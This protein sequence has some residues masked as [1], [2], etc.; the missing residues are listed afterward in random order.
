[1][2]FSSFAPN[3][4]LDDFLLSCKLLLPWNWFKLRYGKAQ[5]QL[6]T[7]IETYF[8]RNCILFD[9]G[10]NALYQ[11]LKAYHFEA[12]SEIIIQALT[13]SVV[14]HA[15][16]RARLQPV[17]TDIDSS[18][19]LDPAKLTASITPQTKAVI[20][21]H[22]FGIPAQIKEIKAI[23]EQHNLILIEDL[24]LSLGAQYE[25]KPVG[26]FGDSAILSF[27]SFKVISCSRGGATITKNE[28]VWQ[29]LQLNRHQTGEAPPLKML[30]RNLW[31][32]I[33]FYISK[34]IYD[35]CKI[36]KIILFTFKKLGLLPIVTSTQEKQASGN[37]PTYTL[38][39]G[40]AIQALHQWHKMGKFRKHRRQIANIY[41]R[42][43]GQKLPKG[44]SILNYP[45]LTPKQKQVFKKAAKH[46]IMLNNWY[47]QPI[48]PA[49]ANLEKCGYRKGSCPQ[50]EKVCQQ[51]VV[52]PTHIGISK[53]TAKRIAKL[54]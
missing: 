11:L 30:L 51:L 45:V 8:E 19:N 26:T 49:D 3:I 32:P 2:I 34:P 46:K 25:G 43:F 33:I 24:A 50:A 18:Y 41:N 16:K 10:R 17:Y 1:M 15:I 48:A 36:G 42:H 38:A 20:I 6:R 5:K 12:D 37:P 35:F 44:S 52:L 14:P 31:Q 4:E 39:N 9:S 27:G 54:F 40:L 23:C 29:E 7:E 13:C 22:T 47:K 21:Q 53:E 28:K